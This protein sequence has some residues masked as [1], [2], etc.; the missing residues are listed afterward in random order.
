MCTGFSAVSLCS[1]QTVTMTPKTVL[2]N[3]NMGIINRGVSA[4]FKSD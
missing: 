3:C 2:Q 4:D 1:V